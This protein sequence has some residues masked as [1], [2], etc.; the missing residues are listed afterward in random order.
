MVVLEQDMLSE[1]VVSV[2]CVPGISQLD[3]GLPANLQL[4]A[5]RDIL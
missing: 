4:L 2:L 3:A 1:G 5:H